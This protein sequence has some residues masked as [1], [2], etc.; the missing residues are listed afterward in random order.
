MARVVTSEDGRYHF[1]YQCSTE[2]YTNDKFCHEC[3]EKLQWDN[4]HKKELIPCPQ[5]KYANECGVCTNNKSM[6]FD[7]C[8]HTSLGCTDGKRK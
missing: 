3:G 7:S 5:C 6:L 1:C 8:W 2:V 4:P